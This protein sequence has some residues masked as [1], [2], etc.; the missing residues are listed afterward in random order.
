MRGRTRSS[1]K[2]VSPTT[3][4]QASILGSGWPMTEKRLLMARSPGPPPRRPRGALHAQRGQLDGIEDLGVAGAAA[5]VAG[6][7]LAHLVAGGR[8]IVGQQGL[9]GEEDARRAVAALGRAQ[10]RE[11]LLQRVQLAA[12]GHPLHRL[13]LAA[14]ALDG[15]GQAGQ[16]GLAVHQHRAGAALPQLAAVL[17]AR[18]VEVL[19]Q[20]LEEGLVDGDQNLA[21]LTVDPERQQRLHR[22][23]SSP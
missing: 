11:G 9:G 4:A 22:R 3:L 19:A 14:L 13:D 15:Q 17:G 1:A 7:G 23:S 6:E 2:R 18:E 5:E 21:L 12:I 10:L 20:H 16:H 8:R